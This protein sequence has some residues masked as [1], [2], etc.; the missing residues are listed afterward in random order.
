MTNMMDMHTCS[1]CGV[2]LV[3]AT[4]AFLHGE[5]VKLD[6]EVVSCTGIHIPAGVD[7]VGGSVAAHGVVVVATI[8]TTVATIATMSD[9][10]SLVVIVASVSSIIPEAKELALEALRSNVAHLKGH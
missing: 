9:R 1:V 5:F 8:A 2:D 4:I 7:V 10:S 6:G 3:I